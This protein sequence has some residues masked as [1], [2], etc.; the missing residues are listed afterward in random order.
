MCCFTGFGLTGWPFE[1]IILTQMTR[2]IS[3]FT[4]LFTKFTVWPT[5]LLRLGAT[6]SRQSARYGQKTSF[7]ALNPLFTAFT[8]PALKGFKPKCDVFLTF[9][10]IASPY[11]YSALQV[12]P[13]PLIFKGKD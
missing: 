6:P 8:A 1:V 12:A 9:E 3:L 2:L 7:I 4:K 10:L 13:L 5:S 11:I